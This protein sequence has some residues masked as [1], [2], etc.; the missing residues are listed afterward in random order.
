M[1]GCKF[2]FVPLD[3]VDALVVDVVV[4]V[5]TLIPVVA[6]DVLP[7]SIEEEPLPSILPSIP[8]ELYV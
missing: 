6:V 8:E 5:D 4:A 7:V 2:A 3:P 1:Y